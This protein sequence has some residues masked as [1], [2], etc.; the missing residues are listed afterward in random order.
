MD[1]LSYKHGP[2]FHN[3]GDRYRSKS[4]VCF[5]DRFLVQPCTADEP[6]VTSG[7]VLTVTMVK[8]GVL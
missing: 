3:E 2:Y 4:R 7:A 1:G 8:Q 6:Q 5:T